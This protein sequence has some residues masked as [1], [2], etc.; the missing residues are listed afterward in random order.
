M[1]GLGTT[2]VLTVAFAAG[3]AGGFGEDAERRPDSSE[4]LF[5]VTREALGRISATEQTHQLVEILDRAGVED[6]DPVTRA[7]ESTHWGIGPRSAATELLAEAWAREAPARGFARAQ[8][9]DPHW[10]RVFATDLFRAWARRDGVGAQTAADAV[11]DDV[12]RK[13]AE[14]SVAYGRFDSDVERAWH[15]YWERWP[16]GQG[17]L[18]RVMRAVA[19]HEGLDRMASRIEALP[20]EQLVPA[21]REAI[22]FGGERDPEAAIA[23]IERYRA[24]ARVDSLRPMTALAQGWGQTDPKAATLWLVERHPSRDRDAAFRL[25]FQSWALRSEAGAEAI[26][27]VE[28]QPEG[29]MNAVLDI[30]AR[31]VAGTHP[32][33]AVE[34]IQKIEDPRRRARIRRVLGH[35]LEGATGGGAEARDDS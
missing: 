7:Y 11:D 30:Y 6:L 3:F 22:R 13:V 2:L 19:A 25:A 23:L 21:L 12:L 14:Q 15:A 17:G 35:A 16:K 24:S 20:G 9:W 1:R 10:A 32:D 5:E 27:W 26:A 4:A 28:S 33:R 18:D 29:V 8:G 34:A 31:A